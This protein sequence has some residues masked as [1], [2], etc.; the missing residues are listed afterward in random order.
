MQDFV[1]SISNYAKDIKP[2][3]IIIPQNGTELAFKDLDPDASINTTYLD[4]VDGFAVEE[5]F[6][7]GNSTTDEY[8]LGMLQQLVNH[9]KVMVADYLSND[10]NFEDAVQKSKHEGF[11]CFPRTSDNYDYR[12]I[13]DSIIDENTNNINSLQDAQNFLYLISTENFST[14]EQMLSAIATTNFDVVLIDLFWDDQ[15]LSTNDLGQIKNKAN[16]G[17]RLLISYIN[18]GAAE[19][20]RYYWQDG[21]KLHKPKWLKK[22]YDGY[23]DEIWVQYWCEDWQ[24]II[25]GNNDPY[26]KKIV[27]AGFDGAF[28]DNVEAY[29][30]LYHD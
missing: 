18:V 8:K 21:W 16:G 22:K 13:P 25:Y 15:P 11:I 3:F 28:L 10:N 9:K 6:Y 27:D 2:G 1:I 12:I 24:D 26:M 20:Y 30:F 5:L 29:Y 4:A 23:D 17:K 7:N 19:K 14:K